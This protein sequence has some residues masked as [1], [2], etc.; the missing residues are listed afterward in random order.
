M[1]D[2]GLPSVYRRFLG[3]SF[4]LLPAELRTF[5]DVTGERHFSGQCSIT[6]AQTWL[7]RAA[8]WMLGL[9]GAADG[10]MS[11]DILATGD[12]ETWRR[13]FPG[14]ILT[15]RLQFER[16]LL[17][18]RMGTADMAFEVRMA[19]ANE[20]SL[21]LKRVRIL[22][23]PM[24]RFVHPRVRAVETASPGTLHFDVAASWPLVGRIVAYR[25]TLD[26][27]PARETA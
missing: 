11:F 9:P 7:G 12:G 23:I 15:S 27:L 1:H 21:A 17:V 13:K 6:G 18:E 4:D 2:A 25:G 24:P 5:H 26:I 14:A 20:L 10:A 16:G 3:P 8:A 22:G 19:N